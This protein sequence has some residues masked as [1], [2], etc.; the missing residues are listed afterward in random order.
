[1]PGPKPTMRCCVCK[2]RAIL[3]ERIKMAM[4]HVSD[5]VFQ[6]L[7]IA[8]DECPVSGC[9][10][11]NACC[12]CLMNRCEDVCRKGTI[13]FDENHAAHIDKDKCVECGMCAMICRCGGLAE[14]VA[15]GIKEHG[16]TDFTLK[17]ISCDG[18]EACKLAL[19]KKAKGLIDVNFIEGMACVGGCI[20][21]AG[22]LTHGDRNKLAVDNFG[23]QAQ[24]QTILSAVEDAD[25]HI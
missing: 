20:D 8:C 19:L 14:T 5:N 6:V 13:R 10:V 2:E 18:I 16:L 24:E 25:R 3:V 23:R 4:G 21:G 15:E 22:C 9:E 17:P 1:M 7:D 12:G 11:T